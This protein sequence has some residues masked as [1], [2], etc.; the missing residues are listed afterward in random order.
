MKRVFTKLTVLLLAGAALLFTGCSKDNTEKPAV[1]PSGE[2]VTKAE[3]E[4]M[5]SSY[6]EDVRRLSKAIADLETNLYGTIS[7]LELRVSNLETALSTK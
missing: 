7:G 1:T 2:Y 5:K 4:A 6:E 3:F